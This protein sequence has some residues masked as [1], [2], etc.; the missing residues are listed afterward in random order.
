MLRRFL[1]FQLSLFEKGTPLHRLRPAISSID[2][3]CRQVPLNT[4]KAPFIR[5]AIDLKRW[6]MLVVYALIPTILMAIWNTGLQKMVYTS[7]DAALMEDYLNASTSIKGYLHFAF[8]EG[9]YWTILKLGSFAFFPIMII[10]YLV[11]GLCEMVSAC[12]K[13][14][15]ISEGF[16]VTGMLY[17]LILPPTIP[18]WM[19]AI[20][21]AFGII[22]GKELF[23]GTGM[24][25][26]NPALIARC[27]LF[28]TFPGKMT[29]D[30]WVGTNPT[31]VSESLNRMN[32]SL[33]L[34]EIDGF[35]Q[36]T[37]LSGLNTAL[38]EI[39]R[40][41]VNA[42]A[43]NHL[44]ADKI[45]GYD[46]ISSH[47]ERWKVAHAPQAELGFLSA[48]QMQDFVTTPLN[49]GG[50]GLLSSNFVAANQF[51]ET[52]YGFGKFSDGN[53]FWGNILGS[54]GETSTFACLLGALFLIYTGI[55]SWRTMLSYGLAA[56]L[57]AWIFEFCSTHFGVDEG[58]WNAAKYAMPAYRHLLMGGL[59]FG[60]VFM[61]TDP[62]SS[63]GMKSAKWVYGALIGL[64]TILIRVINPAFAEG[65]MLAILFGNVFAPLM[66][67]FAV[68]RFRV[69]GKFGE[70]A[71]GRKV[72]H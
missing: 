54:M 56:Y 37:A 63:P 34:N 68:R 49:E 38:P 35:S 51:A 31:Q 53:L 52:A 9:R 17:P 15:E 4:K 46:I 8:N 55:G 60:I 43:T 71:F 14:H 5:D 67:Y 33:N 20:G 30:I 3:F 65:V 1:D 24:N 48:D 64:I 42:L 23:G 69:R 6:M 50:L 41:H 66:D 21:I 57:T 36:A 47:F 32:N 40:I 39:K 29:G 27:F 45:A 12:I 18:Y 70:K 13:G 19:A 58:L 61:A 26:L 59:A 72:T 2:T 25:I 7:G 22:F 16:L 11:G 28:F 10:S 44:G 62:V